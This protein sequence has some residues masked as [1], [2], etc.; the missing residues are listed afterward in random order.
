M[1][2]EHFNYLTLIL[3]TI[4][5][6]QEQVLD[7]M[8]KAVTP[9]EERHLKVDHGVIMPKFIWQDSLAIFDHILAHDHLVGLRKNMQAEMTETKRGENLDT[10][11]ASIANDWVK[12]KN[13]SEVDE[14]AFIADCVAYIRGRSEAFLKRVDDT[15]TAKEKDT[16]ALTK[17]QFYTFLPLTLSKTCN[18]KYIRSK[19]GIRTVPCY[20]SDQPRENSES[21]QVLERV[22]YTIA[23]YLYSGVR[24][25]TIKTWIQT[26]KQEAES[27]LETQKNPSIDTTT[28]GKLFK[29]LFPDRKLSET[30][31]NDAD[32]LTK[33]VNDDVNKV[34]FF[35]RD[36]LSKLD[37]STRKISCDGKNLVSMAAH[38]SGASATLGCLKA[39][40]RDVHT[41]KAVEKG[42]NGKMLLTVMAKA[43]NR[44]FLKF[45][46]STPANIV[47]KIL[48]EERDI[49][50]VVDGVGALHG[51]DAV[52]I[53]QDLLAI[54]SK[55][56]LTGIHLFDSEGKSK[57]L[58]RDG[59]RDQDSVNATTEKM[60][61]ALKEAEARG[62]DFRIGA[63]AQFLI[64]AN[65]RQLLP[66][67]MQT[68]GRSRGRE[69]RIRFAVPESSGITDSNTLVI[70]GLINNTFKEADDLFRANKQELR[71][72]VRKDMLKDLKKLAL[73][74]NL[75]PLIKRYNQ[76]QDSAI[77]VLV[78]EKQKIFHPMKNM[79]LE[80]TSSSMLILTS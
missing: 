11:A 43:G 46:P 68:A 71:D 10:I 18:V 27:E 35:L 9:R 6:R 65:S 36:A 32:A 2:L 75:V 56:A 17:D 33:E 73:Q 60:G 29:S 24:P 45:D 55:A 58:T 15:W 64:T 22:N 19:D 74:G 12:K 52:D 8:D 66:D 51:M 25:S 44:P 26:L 20:S 1:T 16:I 77:K 14:K 50:A 39:M 67:L 38:T 63:H 49:Q 70:D 72:I 3:T 5:S 54:H 13:I 37:I 79:F 21:E 31:E 47:P 78:S 59:L 4:D 48:K 42:T 80:H 30:F 69:Q 7:E 34:R 53:A 41:D 57:V 62:A 76:F 23:D 61:L 28:E 40:H